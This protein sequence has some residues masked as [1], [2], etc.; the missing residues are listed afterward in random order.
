VLAPSSH[1]SQPWR[2]EVLNDRLR[3]WIDS[4]RWLQ[5]ADADRRELNLSVGCALE[6]L[7][8]AAEH[9]GLL[10][11]VSYFP[12]GEGTDLVAEVRLEQGT[13][14]PDPARSA[15]FDAIATR[16]TNHREY[17]GRPLTNDDMAA[18]ESLDQPGGIQIH[19]VRDEAVLRRMEELVTRAD[20]LQFADPAWRHELAAW[21]A[22]GVF[23]KGWLMSK[24]SALAVGHMNLGATTARGDARLL[25][26]AGALGVI[27]CEQP[28][29]TSQVQA[30]QVFERVFLTAAARGVQLHPMNQV[31]QVPEVR[32]A[33]MSML[34]PTWGVPQITFRLGYAQPEGHTPRRQLEEVLQ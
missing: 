23:G 2:F 29:R 9:F 6:N 7:L 33:F 10:P 26:S 12:D 22:R 30:G 8:V 16:H 18:I 31:L 1:N 5:V 11:R 14:P 28:D 32:A 15:L 24:V 17:D 19:L 4:T 34:P 13:R 21:L 3:L 20:E 25:R 27:T